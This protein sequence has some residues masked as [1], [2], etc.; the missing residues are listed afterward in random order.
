MNL[1]QRIA[2]WLDRVTGTPPATTMNHVLASTF[3]DPADVS[4]FKRCKAHG[5]SDEYCFGLGDN[6]IGFTGLD[7]TDDSIPYVALP[8]EDWQSKWG[9]SH[10]AAGKPV[11]VTCNGITA[12]CIM[13]DTM[14]HKANIKNGCGIDLAPGAQ[15]LFGITPGTYPASWQWLS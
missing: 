1:F 2:A 13:G 9:S 11:S 3:A 12:T 7:C 4:A 10:N 14:P 8:V 6:G 5:N 15:K